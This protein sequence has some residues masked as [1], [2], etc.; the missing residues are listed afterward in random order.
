M[1]RNAE[2][3]ALMAGARAA[4]AEGERLWA[5]GDWR[6]AAAQGWAAVREATAALALEVNGELAAPAGLGDRRV[7]AIS[8]SISDLARERGGEWAELDGRFSGVY[9]GLYDPA[10]FVGAYYEEIGDLVREAADYIRCAEELAE[11]A[12]GRVVAD[13]AADGGQGC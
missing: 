9:V 1:L 12:A 2:A 13:L 8:G 7:S 5:A 3:A 6:Q 11:R 4:Q 10:Y